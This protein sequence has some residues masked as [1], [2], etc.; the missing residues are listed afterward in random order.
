MSRPIRILADRSKESSGAG[1]L[2]NLL[3]HSEFQCTDNRERVKKSV[4]SKYDVLAICG[5]SLKRFTRAELTSI[6]EFVETGGGLILAAEAPRFELDANQPVEKMA[7]NAVAGLFG[8]AFLSGDCKGAKADEGLNIRLPHDDLETHKHPSLGDAAP[9][10]VT[11]GGGPIEP[12]QGAAILA[13]HKGAGQPVAAAFDCGAGRVVMVGCSKFADERPATCRAIAQWLAGKRRRLEGLDKPVPDYIGPRGSIKR[14]DRF[15][16]SYDQPC[17]DLIDDVMSLLERLDAALKARFGDAW[18]PKTCFHLADT[19]AGAERWRHWASDTICAQAPEASRVCELLSPPFGTG[20]RWWQVCHAIPGVFTNAS[21]RIH[22]MLEM[23]EELGYAEEAARCRERADRWIAEMDGRAATFDLARAYHWTDEPY[24]RGLALLREFEDAQGREPIRKLPTVVPE[25]DPNKHLPGNYAWPSDRAIY[26][27]SLAAEKDLF[28]WFAERGMTVHP[29]PIVKPEARNV[30]SRMV[31]RLNEA[32]R[33]DSEALSSR[34]DAAMD[35]AGM[36]KHTQLKQDDWGTLCAAL[37]L[38]KSGDARAARKLKKLFERAEPPIRAIAGVALA[39]LGDASVGEELVSLA[40]QFEPRFQ[41]AAHYSLAKA[42]SG[43]ADEL[44]LGNLTDAQGNLVGEVEVKYDGY[45]AMHCKVEGY[46]V[47][48]IFSRPNL[49]GFTADGAFSVH[50]VHWAHTSPVWRRRGLSRCLME[51]TVNHPAAMKCSCS[52]LGTGTRNLAHPLYR[53]YGFIDVSVSEQC[54]CEL[55]GRASGRLPAGVTFRE[56]AEGDGAKSA[57]LYR[58][59]HGAALNFDGLPHYELGPTTIAY[60]AE[61]D[62]K[63]V[64]AVAA[65]YASGDE[66]GF[67][68]LVVREG[69]DRD[70]IADALLG[71]LHSALL[72]AG[73][74]R[75]QHYHPPE[76][77]YLRAALNRA[78][79]VIKPT[80]GVWMM[81]VRHLAQFLNEIAPVIGK[82]LAKSDFKQWQGTIDLLG[83]RLQAR[84][85]V[86]KGKIKAQKP[87]AKPADIVLTCDDD[88]VTRIAL[89]RETPF[90]AYLQIRLTIEP[91]VSE[92]ITR[93]LEVVFPKVLV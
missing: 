18:K 2:A 67:R 13:S 74:K 43:Q 29:F 68:V 64:G 79:Y 37:K 11:G 3:P 53:S 4:L 85:A 65:Y 38:G 28:P 57:A 30:K 52:E 82:R 22:V 66:A 47:N 62:G 39:D 81:Q 1:E 72:E 83:S 27:L 8:A 10:L 21:W 55:P 19:L 46:K 34:M 71:C 14:G 20:D 59:A 86:S 24:P 41:L 40:R 16:V 58:E 12:P 33:D 51:K 42:G 69:D 23:L 26:Y 56:Y 70:K 93:L 73:A 89:G 80:G 88:T 87:G 90:E 15:H 49:H 50:E 25:K 63:L 84:I 75:V 35:L 54:T 92:E 91:R 17:A 78:G 44:A 61:Q 48:N 45:I 77:D 6:Q 5:Q 76:H 31:A 9:G 32:L 7:Q 36:A 60:L